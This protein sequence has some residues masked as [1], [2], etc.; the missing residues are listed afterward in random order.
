MSK[1]AWKKVIEIA[2]AILSLIGGMIVENATG[3]MSMVLR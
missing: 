1:K 2:I 3:A